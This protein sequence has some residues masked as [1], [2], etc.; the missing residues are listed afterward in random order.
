MTF[1][2]KYFKGI[3]QDLG[4]CIIH[5]LYSVCIAMNKLMKEKGKLSVRI[6]SQLWNIGMTKL[7]SHYFAATAVIID[8]SSHH[9]WVLK[10][11]GEFVRECI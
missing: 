6:D 3:S 11:A 8:L 4:V 9:L 2:H 7:E 5:S 10:L 1:L